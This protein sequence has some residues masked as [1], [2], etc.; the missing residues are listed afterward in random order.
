MKQSVNN[1]KNHLGIPTYRNGPKIPFLM[2]SDDCII[3]EKAS[4]NACDNINRILQKFCA[5]FGQLVKFHKSV[6]QFSNNMQG[7]TKMRLRETL[8]IPISNG[9]SKY[10]GCPLVQGRIKRSIFLK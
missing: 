7:V 2:F 10:L 4:Q 5:L 9:I 6:V 3:F 1:P 8:S